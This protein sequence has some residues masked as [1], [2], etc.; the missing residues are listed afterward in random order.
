L[1]ESDIQV[2]TRGP[3]RSFD[4]L[5]IQLVTEIERTEIRRAIVEFIKVTEKGILRR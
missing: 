2:L 5:A 3:V 4:G 1:R